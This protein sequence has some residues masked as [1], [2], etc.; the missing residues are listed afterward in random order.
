MGLR[1]I[2]F[3]FLVAALFAV[4]SSAYAQDQINLQDIQKELEA[5]QKELESFEPILLDT[6]LGDQKLFDTRQAVK[7]IRVRLFEIQDLVKPLRTSV[8]AEL[9]DLGPKP[10]GEVADL[11]PENIKE[12]RVR[13]EKESILIKGILTQAEAL[14]AKSTRFLE[15]LAAIRRTQ[16]VDKILENST[17]PFNMELWTEANRDKDTA[18]A[19]L[20]EGWLNFIAEKPDEERG[21]MYR[22][23]VIAVCLFFAIYLAALALNT[24]K[25]LRRIGVQED[26]SMRWK[27]EKT[28]FRILYTVIAG[29]VGLAIVFVVVVRHG[30]IASGHENFGYY[31]FVFSLFIVYAFTK[32]WMLSSASVVRK[33]IGILATTA[34]ALFA[35]DFL[36]LATGQHFGVP[37]E[38]AIA[39]SFIV[40]T[41]FSIILL[42]FFTVLVRKK[43]DTEKMYFFKRRFF[44]FGLAL[45]AFI[46]GANALGYVA[47]TRFIFEQTIL[48]SN[49]FMALVILRAMIRPVLVWGE[50]FFYQG[51]DQEDR[52]ALFWLS[53]LVDAFLVALSFPIVAAIVGVEWEGIKL[54]IVQALFGFKIGGI[55][56]SVTSVISAIAVF[57]MLLF[58]TRFLQKILSKKVLPKTRMAESVQLSFVQII[59][60]IGLTTAFMTA[61]SSVGFDLSN[62]ALIAGAL[63]VGIGFGLQSI[64]NNFVS[65]LILL[66]ERPIKVGDW[67][68]L[69]SGE[70]VVKKISVRAT[71][72]ETLDRTSIIIPNSELISSSVKNWTHKDRIGRVIITIGVSYDCDPKRVHDLLLE[73][74]R[75]NA[76]VLSSPLPSI[77]FRDFGDSALIFD[78]RVFLRNITDRIA[79]ATTLRLEIWEKL[80]AEG[81]EIPFP[82]RDLH[83]RSADGMK[84]FIDG[85]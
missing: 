28:G 68:I 83:I 62:L 54:L 18:V 61:I 65:G 53:L 19:E 6:T 72:I 12:L 33:T 14:S 57:V 76:S 45:G 49:F 3:V 27:L 31:L 81:I 71:E 40:T 84:G 25:L 67:V 34:T 50:K 77:H 63:S 16:F 66:F 4:M 70:G 21:K 35:I 22:A 36:L 55:T 75:D 64:V 59:G 13:L 51:P 17:S 24:R 23:V 85:R 47:L 11:E 20:Y 41:V 15:T 60:Y 52:L 56:I 37:V 2:H 79:V 73:V 29:F 1:K 5:T 39:Q 48:L 82:Q 10:D 74:A 44:Y 32:S 30:L 78:L 9:T 26:P 69:N 38:L 42:A 80:K 8:A 46:L 43:Q 58:I 7:Q